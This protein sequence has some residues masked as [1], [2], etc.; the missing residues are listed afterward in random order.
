[1]NPPAHTEHPEL[2]AV[3]EIWPSEMLNAL[4]IVLREGSM[5]AGGDGDAL[6]LSSHYRAMAWLFVCAE[7]AR[8][9]PW[10]SNSEMSADV[11]VFWR[12]QESVV[13]AETRSTLPTWSG[14]DITVT[15][16]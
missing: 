8:D 2:H 6:L 5:A 13:F 3:R 1:M 9:E 7:L 12:S 14:A 10:F 4:W 16:P 15:F 11:I